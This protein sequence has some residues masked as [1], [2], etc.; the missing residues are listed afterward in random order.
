MGWGSTCFIHLV[1]I[2]N[3]MISERYK[4]RQAYKMVSSMIAT[5]LFT[6]SL[7]VLPD[8]S[9]QYSFH[10]LY[11]CLCAEALPQVRGA[12]RYSSS[13]SPLSIPVVTS[14]SAS[15]QMR[16]ILFSFERQQKTVR[17]SSPLALMLTLPQSLELKACILNSSLTRAIPIVIFCVCMCVG[18]SDFFDPSVTLCVC[19]C[20]WRCECV[21]TSLITHCETISSSVVCKWNI[22]QSFH[23]SI[24]FTPFQT[25]RYLGRFWSIDKHQI[26]I[27]SSIYCTWSGCIIIQLYSPQ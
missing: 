26:E 25:N 4:D 15:L 16:P 21:F 1:S 12:N 9:F 13:V 24:H 22:S 11:F 17:V 8:L 6:I 18:T 14:V 5:M 2:F 19:V 10:K 7:S 23:S 20:A 27:T 3:L